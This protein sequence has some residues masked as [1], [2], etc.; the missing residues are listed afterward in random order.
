MGVCLG[1]IYI[2]VFLLVPKMMTFGAFVLAFLSLV[3][4]GIILIAQPINMLDQDGNFWNI[5]VGIMVI[6]VAIFFLVFLCIHHR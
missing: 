6:I 3:T 2:I 4:L 5:F 1:T